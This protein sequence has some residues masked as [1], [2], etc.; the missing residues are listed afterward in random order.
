MSGTV[1][2]EWASDSAVISVPTIRPVSQLTGNLY[3]NV[4]TPTKIDELVV[5]KLRKLGEVPSDLCTDAAFLRR[6]S[7]DIRDP[8]GGR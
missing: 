8:Q 4:P 3:P 2:C 7:L 5:Q 1:F 6:V